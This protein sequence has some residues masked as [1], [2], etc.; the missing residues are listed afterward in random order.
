MRQG[1]YT[2]EH[3]AAEAERLLKDDVLLEAL[4]RIQQD[5]LDDLVQVDATNMAEVMRLQAMAR[6]TSEI[7][8]QLNAMILAL[9]KD[10][11]P[12]LE[13]GTSGQTH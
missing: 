12:D 1:E 13:T 11:I 10:G 2:G 5:A 6:C 8:V 4:H 9:N 7:L 3:L